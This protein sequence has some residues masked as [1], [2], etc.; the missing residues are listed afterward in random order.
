MFNK[1]KKNGILTGHKNNKLSKKYLFIQRNKKIMQQQKVK[2]KGQQ[3]ENDKILDK[4]LKKFSIVMA[5]Y[6]RKKQLKITLDIFEKIYNNKYDF[7][8][9]IVDDASNKENQV[10]NL[11]K[12]YSFEIELLKISENEK[13]NRI[14]SSVV[15]NKGF[16]RAKGEIVIIQNPE[17][18]HIGDLLSYLKD[19][20][21]DSDYFAFSCFTTNTEE[22]TNELLNSD[23]KYKK[24]NDKNFLEKNASSCYHKLKLNWFNHPIIRP[25]GY[26]F[27]SAIHK[28]NLIKIGG[29]DEK[30][31]DGYCFDDDE[32]L[33]SIKYILKLNIIN[34]PPE[35][36]F[37]IH[38]HHSRSV[39]NVKN[40]G[41][42]YTKNKILFL[43]KREYLSKIK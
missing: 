26:H 31:K 12:K 35:K 14:N 19:N 7:E 41:Q 36:G 23:N 38:Q 32:L 8:V 10:D 17:C 21:K 42:L 6:N 9:I 20:L 2:P 16:Q 39:Y 3:L 43:Q 33:L 25:Q 40:L 24:I 22:F 15:Y 4:N 11:I 34:I 27:C 1:L 5:Y 37:V 30:F 18:C 28:K 13:G 29:F